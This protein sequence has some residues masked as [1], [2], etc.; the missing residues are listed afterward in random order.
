M[1]PE[2]T[3]RARAEEFRVAHDLGVAPISD[4]VEFLET[5]LELNVAVLKMSGV[6]AMTRRDPVTGAMVIA[7]AASNRPERQRFSLAHELGHILE[8]D[9]THDVALVHQNGAVESKANGFARHLLAPLAGVRALADHSEGNKERTVAEV[10]RH[11][12][13]SPHV[14]CI[15]L[16]GLGFLNSSEE[17]TFR[18]HNAGWYA[19]R[20]GWD[21]E[22]NHLVRAALDVRPP[23]RVLA[24]AIDAHQQGLIGAAVVARLKGQSEKQTLDEL[25]PEQRPLEEEPREDELAP[26]ET[27]AEW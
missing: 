14:A 20:Y 15:Q 4:M 22:R 11:F 26:V 16:R 23:Q 27:E 10:V 17:K 19:L 8:D 9:F 1:S 7:V 13:V 3:G 12:R 21:T 2:S 18:N 6:E 5:T 25:P 24:R